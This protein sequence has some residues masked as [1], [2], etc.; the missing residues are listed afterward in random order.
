MN[1]LCPHIY[2]WHAVYVLALVPASVICLFVETTEATMPN[3]T[4]DLLLKATKLA[5]RLTP[6]PAPASCAT[7]FDEF[8]ATHNVAGALIPFMEK[9]WPELMA[10]DCGE[11]LWVSLTN[12]IVDEL[13]ELHYQR[14]H[15]PDGT[16]KV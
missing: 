13:K 15:Y 11:D 1:K 7:E 12:L 2:G 16:P 10:T 6:P 5:R 8:V 14:D 4:D 9:N 3:T